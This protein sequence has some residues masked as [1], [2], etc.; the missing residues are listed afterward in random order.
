MCYLKTL[1]PELHKKFNDDYLIIHDNDPK[2]NS[3]KVYNYMIKNK[4]KWVSNI[5]V[6]ITIVSNYQN[7]S[8]FDNQQI[9]LNS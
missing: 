3:D 9:N 2:H 4:L 8:V 1:K 6:L 7:L 5:M